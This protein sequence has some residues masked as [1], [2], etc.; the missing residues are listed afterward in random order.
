MKA[1]QVHKNEGI[2]TVVHLIRKLEAESHLLVQF[3]LMQGILSVPLSNEKSVALY[4]VIQESLTNAMRHSES[5]EVQVTL[6]RSATGDISFMISNTVHQP[7]AFHYGFG[8]SN[9]KKRVEELK[10]KL[11]AYQTEKQFIVEGVIPGEEG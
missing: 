10:G 4:R 8:L 2:A 5:R 3:T 7:T 9:M 1:L 11:S 6:G